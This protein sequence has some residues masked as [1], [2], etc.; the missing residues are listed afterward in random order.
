M[1]AGRPVPDPGGIPGGLRW[2]VP[3]T[4]N[5]AKG[6]WELVVDVQNKLIVHFLFKG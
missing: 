4:C 3:G 5:G 1:K 6:I 2:D